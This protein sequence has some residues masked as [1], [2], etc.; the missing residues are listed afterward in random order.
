MGIL[1]GIL[2]SLGGSSSSGGGSLVRLALQLVQEN[3]GLEGIVAR[4]QKAGLGEKAASW[5]GTGENLPVSAE[6]LQKALGSGALGDL[7]GKL[8]LPQGDALSG[9]TSLLPTL[10]DKMTPNGQLPAE[11]ND[12]LSQVLAS[13]SEKPGRG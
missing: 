3:G 6:E 9:L 13:L 8:G 5:V 12:L 1:D 2:G 10:V 11:G 7:A 4:F